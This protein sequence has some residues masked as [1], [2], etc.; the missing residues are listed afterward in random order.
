MLEIALEGTTRLDSI[1]RRLRV[2]TER[3]MIEL[4]G[5]MYEKVIANLSGA[6]L[7]TKTGQ[8]VGSIRQENRAYGDI[9]VG[10]VYPAP[11]S[12]KAWAL[13]KGGSGYYPIEATKAQML[14]FFAKSGDEVFTKSVNHPPSLEFAYMRKALE[15]VGALIPSG[16][17]EYIQTVLDG[18]DYG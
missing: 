18:G 2:A 7:Q 13:E 3:K 17:Q 1:G 10:E 8:L 6:V 12:P 5:L 15:E 14:H 11:A 9:Y 4:T 16:F